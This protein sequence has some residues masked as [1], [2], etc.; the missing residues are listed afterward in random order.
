MQH[1]DD[2]R[3]EFQRLVVTSLL[4]RAVAFVLL[5]PDHMADAEF[6]R[7]RHRVVGGT[8]VHQNHLVH[9]VRGHLTVGLLQSLRGV[10]SR[11]HDYDF[12]SFQH[13]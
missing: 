8:V 3:P 6:L 5:V 11:H 7:H 10:V 4:V 12:L 9:D 2:I 1:D 13:F